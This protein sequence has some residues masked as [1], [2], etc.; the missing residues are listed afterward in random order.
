[1]L[2]YCNIYLSVQFF[3]KIKISDVRSIALPYIFSN[4]RKL[5]RSTRITIH[6]G[7][8]A[9]QVPYSR[10]VTVQRGN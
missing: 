6:T 4:I 8:A 1:M 2:N 3:K 9:R 5:C 10:Y 7:K